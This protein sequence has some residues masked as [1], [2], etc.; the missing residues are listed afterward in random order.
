MN[1]IKEIKTHAHHS[2]DR[3]ERENQIIKRCRQIIERKEDDGE[4]C[5]CIDLF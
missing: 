3:D 2:S 5:C 1:S 4:I